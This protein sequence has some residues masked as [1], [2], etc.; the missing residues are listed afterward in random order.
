[1]TPWTAA[2]QAPPS[3]GFSRQEYWSGV[4][5]PSPLTVIRR[6]QIPSP[7]HKRKQEAWIWAPSPEPGGKVPDRP[8]LARAP[9]RGCG[10]AAARG[11]GCSSRRGNRDSS[12]GGAPWRAILCPLPGV[13]CPGLGQQLRRFICNLEALGTS[14][15]TPNS[16]AKFPA[17]LPGWPS[18]TQLP[19]DLSKQQVLQR[20]LCGRTLTPKARPH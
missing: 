4:P 14:S 6:L 19:P 1:M 15:P 16:T 20:S 12:R 17:S 3:M 18:G 10:N 7:V 8:T 9:A 13:F 11:C 2:H 5:L